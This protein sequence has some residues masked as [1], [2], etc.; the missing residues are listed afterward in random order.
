MFLIYD[1]GVGWVFGLG[2][3]LLLRVVVCVGLDFGCEVD[4]ARLCYD[5]TWLLN[6]TL[7][8]AVVRF[9]QYG[10]DLG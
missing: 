1:L 10:F 2:C 8:I 9:V 3:L 6:C 5:G 7:I 4:L